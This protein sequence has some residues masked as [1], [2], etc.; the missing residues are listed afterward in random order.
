MVPYTYSFCHRCDSRVELGRVAYGAKV[1][2]PTCGSEFV[3]ESPTQPRD[4]TGQGRGGGDELVV[5]AEEEQM[6]LEAAGVGSPLGLFFSGTFSFPFRLRVLWQTLTLCAGA[7]ALFAAFRLGAW[8]VSVDNESVDKATRILLW[9]GLLLSITFGAVALP[10]WIYV[11]VTGVAAAAGWMI[12]FRLAG[13]LAWF[14]FF[15][16]GGECRHTVKGYALDAVKV[17]AGGAKSARTRRREQPPT[18]RQ[19]DFCAEGRNGIMS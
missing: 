2:C 4:A 7:V 18:C 15:R 3:I 16:T 9:N 14:L 11:A 13:R 12:Y 5:Q 8:C 6:A 1:A 10:A 17:A 19:A